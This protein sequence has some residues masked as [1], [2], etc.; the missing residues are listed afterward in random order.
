ME[1][2]WEFLSKFETNF[3]HW[4][5]VRIYSFLALVMLNCNQTFIDCVSFYSSTDNIQLLALVVRLNSVQTA[6]G[7]T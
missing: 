4:L 1:K 3:N 6:S 7:S 2:R 5:K